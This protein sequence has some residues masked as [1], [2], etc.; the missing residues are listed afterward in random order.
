VKWSW[1]DVDGMGDEE[2]H[3]LMKCAEQVVRQRANEARLVASRGQADHDAL[4]DRLKVLRILVEE[5]DEEA[6]DLAI[7]TATVRG[8]V[9]EMGGGL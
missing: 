5:L 7:R 3:E 2:L 8:A 9:T 6:K 1:A 4:F